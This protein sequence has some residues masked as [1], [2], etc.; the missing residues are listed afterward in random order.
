MSRRRDESASKVTERSSLHPRTSTTRTIAI[1]LLLSKMNHTLGLQLG[2][3]RPDLHHARPLTPRRRSQTVDP[4]TGHARGDDDAVQTLRGRPQRCRPPQEVAVVL[5][6]V[7]RAIL[8]PAQLDRSY[9]FTASV[10]H[11]PVRGGSLAGDQLW[12]PPGPVVTHS[13]IVEPMFYFGKLAGLQCAAP[14]SKAGCWRR[15]LVEKGL[16]RASVGPRSV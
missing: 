2:H 8:G 14:C 6:S 11:H 16:D 5:H 10:E 1:R 13:A 4:A 12:M 15:P 9:A 3:R 7:S